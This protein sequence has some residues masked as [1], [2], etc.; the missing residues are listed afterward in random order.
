MLTLFQ[1]LSLSES[2]KSKKYCCIMHPGIYS[3]WRHK[4]IYNALDIEFS[5]TIP[6][7]HVSQALVICRRSAFTLVPRPSSDLPVRTWPNELSESKGKWENHYLE[8][9]GVDSPGERT[10]D[11]YDGWE[12]IV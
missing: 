1:I 2:T 8:L 10:P 11:F 4:A 3:R 12:L 5:D 9:P 6:P 7:W